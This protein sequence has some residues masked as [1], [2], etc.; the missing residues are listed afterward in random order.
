MEIDGCTRVTDILAWYQDLSKI[1]VEALERKAAIG[2]AVHEAIEAHLSG[3]F[4]VST[5]DM[6]GYMQ[7]F[8]KWINRMDY[9][10]AATEERFFD[11]TLGI[12]GKIDCITQEK[13]NLMLLD[14]KTSRKANPKIWRLQGGF[15][16]ILASQ[17]YQ[18]GDQF[19]FLQL[20]PDGTV[21]KEHLYTWDAELHRTCLA[22]L[23]TYRYFEKKDS[24][25]CR[26]VDIV[27][28]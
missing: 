27:D 13:D 20:M 12:T 19:L 8:L 25:K 15:Y 22:I 26:K 11:Y 9:A 7:S 2:T 24:I 14:F 5:D 21:A 23:E 6:K 3:N 18:L 10:V 16:H 1:P 28:A 4:Y 17:K